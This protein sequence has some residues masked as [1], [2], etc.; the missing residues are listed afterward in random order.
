MYLLHEVDNAY[1]NGTLLQVASTV[2]TEIK[3]IFLCVKT[4]FSSRIRARK[5]YKLNDCEDNK[6]KMFSMWLKNVDHLI[7]LLDK[8]ENPL[9][10]SLI[11]FS[12]TEYLFFNT[13]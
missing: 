7:P 12:R 6:N 10:E 8:T 2:R 13:V 11:I 9:C 4:N 5:E 3:D 1:C